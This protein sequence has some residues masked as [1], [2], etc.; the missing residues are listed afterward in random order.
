[1]I[2]LTAKSF[3]S[4][5]IRHPKARDA[6]IRGTFMAPCADSWIGPFAIHGSAS[7]PVANNAA[8]R[9]PAG[10][11][12]RTWVDPIAPWQA[13][14][15]KTGGTRWWL[16]LFPIIFGGIGVIGLSASLLKLTALGA[17]LFG[18]K[19]IVHRDFQTP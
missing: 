4:P 19:R 1:M 9:Y 5:L 17:A 2:F 15:E 11:S 10:S 13:V 3:C 12:T 6:A 16:W 7:I 8:N 18:A 14:L